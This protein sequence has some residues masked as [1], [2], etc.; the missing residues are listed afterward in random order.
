MKV[1]G[2]NSQDQE[3]ISPIFNNMEDATEKKKLKKQMFWVKKKVLLVSCLRH[4]NNLKDK[5]ARKW[6]PI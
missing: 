4:E 5:I 6:G 1:L 2:N 3:E